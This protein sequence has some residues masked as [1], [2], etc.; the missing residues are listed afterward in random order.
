MGRRWFRGAG[1]ILAQAE[2]NAAVAR[3]TDAELGAVVA[4][5][6]YGSDDT[7]KAEQPGHEL[8]IATK[9]D[10]K[11]RAELR[12]APPPRG[13]I[14]KTITTRERMDRTLRTKFGREID[15]QRSQTVEPVFG[16]A[17]GANGV[18]CTIL[19]AGP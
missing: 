4:D 2:G 3:D 7:M 11:E 14:P 1:G 18:S 5:A 19:P 10:H 16:P 8:F 13:R 9:K 17:C 12:E 15:A 6:G